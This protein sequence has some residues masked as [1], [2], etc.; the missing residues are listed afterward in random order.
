MPYGKCVCKQKR[1]QCIDSKQITEKNEQIFF[2]LSRVLLIRT[3]LH[4]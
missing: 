2:T 1:K 4:L 3:D